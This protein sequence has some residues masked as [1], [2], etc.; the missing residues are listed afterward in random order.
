MVTKKEPQDLTDGKWLEENQFFVK[1]N[2]VNTTDSG[3]H[4]ELDK[5]NGD[6]YTSGFR[7]SLPLNLD[8]I[9]KV[10][11]SNIKWTSTEPTDTDIKI[12][13]VISDSNTVEPILSVN[14]TFEYTGAVQQYTVPATGTYKIKCWGGGHNFSQ[15]A[16]YG[17]YVEGDVELTKDD[18]LNIYV[19]EKATAAG[20]WNGGG[21][22]PSSTRQATGGAGATDIRLNGT[23]LADR[24]IVAGGAGGSGRDGPGTGP[25]SA[26][27]GGS[28]GA[29][30]GESG[31]NGTSTSGGG[32]GGTQTAGGTGANSGSLG[33]GGNGG[34]NNNGNGGGGGGGYYGGGGG[35]GTTS[36]SGRGAGGGGGSNY[37][38][39]DF[40]DTTNSRGTTNTGDGEVQITASRLYQEATNDSTIPGI[41]V[42]DDLTGKYLWVRQELSTEDS[43]ETPR[44]SSLE[45]NVEQLSF[46]IKGTVNLNASPVEGAKVR[47]INDTTNTYIGDTLTDASGNY[48]FSVSSDTA[49]HHAMVEYES[50]GNKYHALSKPFIKGGEE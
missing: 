17:G 1:E 11:F 29:D 19:G 39:E 4:L 15:G 8:S 12:Y 13:T 34:Q 36:S 50:G 7:T 49:D 14:E 3:E 30:I 33:V 23:A 10:V 22:T 20:G 9:K 46:T 26:S 2:V 37:I 21:A 42:D 38:S 45:I 41:S 43:E 44:L 48:E 18:V 5:D 35:Y 32:T 40:T 16:T 31:N 47:L 24:I 27:K 25:S 6:Y 28:G